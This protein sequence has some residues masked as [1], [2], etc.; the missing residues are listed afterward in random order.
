MQIRRA[1]VPRGHTVSAGVLDVKVSR[2]ERTFSQFVGRERE[3]AVLAELLEQVE[4]GQGQVV[5]LVAVAG[6]GKS[7]LA[8]RAS[9]SRFRAASPG[10]P[11]EGPRVEGR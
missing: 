6:G 7:R 5:G 9:P 3:L 2:G 11:H 10:R 1:R 4:S 8:F